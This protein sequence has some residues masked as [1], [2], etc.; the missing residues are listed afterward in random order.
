MVAVM[1][2]KAESARLLHEQT[3]EM[4]LDHFVL[5]SSIANLVGNSRQ[6][7]YVS[8]NGFLD[9]LAWHRRALGLP[10]TSINWGAIA[11]VGVV[12][13]DEKLEQFMRYMGLRGMESTEALRWLERAMLRD[14]TQLGITLITNWSDWGRY[15][16]LGAQSPRYA[17]LIAAD[18]NPHAD[19][20][21]V[22]RGE[23]ADLPSAERFTVLASLVASLIADELGTAAQ[24]I[25]VDR[26]ILELG[27]DSLMATEIQL[28]L[29]R[30]LGIGVSVLEILDDLTI[31]AIVD[32]ALTAFGWGDASVAA[33]PAAQAA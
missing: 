5:Y 9:G 22:L 24:A 20:A 25:P 12:T 17:E 2:A 4:T 31:R 32:R 28:L 29:S 30:D 23:L 14:F 13:R 21:A 26:P 6:A 1:S 3:R 11:D 33:G 19:P 27:V 15:E 10:A 16:T 7:S 18:A 8:A